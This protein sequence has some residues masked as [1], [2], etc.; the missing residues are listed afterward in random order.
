MLAMLETG[1]FTSAS[2]FLKSHIDRSWKA[3][4]HGVAYLASR[5]AAD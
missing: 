2:Q 1:D 4:E 3:K 5:L